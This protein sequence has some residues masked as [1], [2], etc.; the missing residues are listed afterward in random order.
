MQSYIFLFKKGEN[1]KSIIQY[2]AYSTH[3]YTHQNNAISVIRRFYKFTIQLFFTQN[4]YR[5]SRI[6]FKA[7]C[8]KNQWSL[9]KW[10]K[11]Q[12]NISG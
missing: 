3:T 1:E 2:N 12:N 10:M 11:C 6:N 4:Y 5:Q 9:V 7:V 8:T